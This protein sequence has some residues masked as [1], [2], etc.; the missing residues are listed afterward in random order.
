LLALQLSNLS[1]HGDHPIFEIADLLHE[2]GS[3]GL[4]LCGL[5]RITLA[6]ITRQRDR[7]NALPKKPKTFIGN[8]PVWNS[9]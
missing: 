1:L 7:S 4:R 3:V 2:G 9:R 8:T 5:A 6:R